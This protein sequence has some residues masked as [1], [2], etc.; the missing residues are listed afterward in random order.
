VAPPGAGKTVIAC[1]LIARHSTSTLVL[2]DRKALADQWRSRIAEHLGVKA[3][4]LGG[5]RRK[6]HGSV[7]VA[8]LQ[9]LVRQDDIR[10]VTAA[11]GLVV[12]DECHHVPAAA[13]E[14]AVKQIPAR[15][16]IGLT[17]TPYRRDQLDDLITLQLGPIRY[18]M[19]P[20]EP[21]T[22]TQRSAE[23]APPH[24]VLQVHPTAFTYAGTIEPSSLGGMPAVYRE[25][26]A[27]DDRNQQIVDDV[28]DALA[29]GRNCLVLTRWTT[30][31]ERLVAALR[32]Y[33]HDPVVLRG[34]MGAKARTAALVRLTNP[35]R[36]TTTAGSRNRLVYRRRLRLPRARHPLPHRTHR[37]QR[38]T[39]A[40]RGTH[41]ANTSR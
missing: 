16:W 10:A 12:V 41:P 26:A 7:D 23:L 9:S 8:M 18:T 5:G 31:L 4:E 1:A 24:P 20:A 33:G 25:L 30:H 19:T 6:T 35:P 38:S 37:L 2:V 27:D 13:F 22:L 34:G 39:R 15:R 32:E 11:Y 40:V 36:R 28:L 3:G 14:H 29:R 21:G 17:A